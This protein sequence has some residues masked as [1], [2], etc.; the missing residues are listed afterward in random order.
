MR[1]FILAIGLVI[2]APL[3]LGAQ[4]PSTARPQ[5]LSVE[6]SSLLTN[7]WARLAEG[8]LGRAA[9]LLE[10]LRLSFPRSV[11]VL[12][13]GVEIDIARSGPL[14]ALDGYERWHGVGSL[15]SPF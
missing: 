5:A 4:Q 7:G 11:H 1:M 12:D 3:L 6:E 10:T 2:S 15:E 13:L 14:V 9:Q 8:D